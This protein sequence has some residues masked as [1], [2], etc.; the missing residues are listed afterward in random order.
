[1]RWIDLQLDCFNTA[2]SINRYYSVSFLLIQSILI[3]DAA[4]MDAR[5]TAEKK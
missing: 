5:I 2:I 1:M 3:P 4:L